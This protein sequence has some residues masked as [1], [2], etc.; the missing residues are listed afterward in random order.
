[1]GSSKKL[2]CQ[3]DLGA[4]KRG[5]YRNDQTLQIFLCLK[6]RS[7]M[8]LFGVLRESWSALLA[9]FSRIRMCHIIYQ[10]LTQKKKKKDPT[11]RFY[12]HNFF[13]NINFEKKNGRQICKKLTG[14]IMVR[15]WVN[16]TLFFVA[17]FLN[18]K[19]KVVKKYIF[20]KW[21]HNHQ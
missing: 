9:I 11:V 15:I 1:M 5:G 4:V 13:I 12:F 19:M 16:S 7:K 17:V 18:F 14:L 3:G 8:N 6:F 2:V 20:K 10:K 21:K